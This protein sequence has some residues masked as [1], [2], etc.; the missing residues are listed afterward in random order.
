MKNINW[1]I[2]RENVKL[3]FNEQQFIELCEDE[4]KCE[5]KEEIQEL[6]INLLEEEIKIV[7]CQHRL[8]QIRKILAIITMIMVTNPELLYIVLKEIDIDEIL[9]DNW[10][11]NVEDMLSNFWLSCIKYKK[12]DC[13]RDT[14][15]YKACLY[16]MYKLLPLRYSYDDDTLRYYCQVNFPKKPKKLNVLNLQIDSLTKTLTEFVSKIEELNRHSLEQKEWNRIFSDILFKNMK[17]NY[18]IEEEEIELIIQEGVPEEDNAGNYFFSTIN[19]FFYEKFGYGIELINTTDLVNLCCI[20]L[21][22]NLFLINDAN[23]IYAIFKEFTPAEFIKTY[24]EKMNII[25]FKNYYY[26]WNNIS[27]DNLENIT[28]N[29]CV[30][31]LYELLLPTTEDGMYHLGTTQSIEQVVDI[32][33]KTIDDFVKEEN[34]NNIKSKKI[35]GNILFRRMKEKNLIDDEKL[36]KIEVWQRRM[37][38]QF[39]FSY[40][41]G[42]KEYEK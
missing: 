3:D 42:G 4:K 23:S 17:N 37:S 6:K 8:E 34:D 25:S 32:I 36:S 9:R 26:V 16:K 33:V 11:L 12:G 40:N 1:F 10:Y 31:R 5:Q 35:L 2:D 27:E 20:N 13:S 39:L 18:L 21:I 15:K 19:A 24:D 22:L 38:H 29:A 7:K 14:I 41:E 28:L 30:Y